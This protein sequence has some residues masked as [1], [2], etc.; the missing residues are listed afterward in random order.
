MAIRKCIQIQVD[1]VGVMRSTRSTVE[2]MDDTTTAEAVTA[3][4][5]I[6][7]PFDEA[8]G[9]ENSIRPIEAECRACAPPPDA[10]AERFTEAWYAR[11][12]LECIRSVRACLA[13]GHPEAGIIAALRLGTYIEQR[14]WWVN[15]GGDVKSGARV[16]RKQRR[17]SRAGVDAR[18]ARTVAE[19]ETLRVTVA[20]YRAKHSYSREH[21]TRALAAHCA[22]A[23]KRK[24]AGVRGRL[25]V[26]K[27]R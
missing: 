25:D 3:V 26:L 6:M 17:A 14:K 5:E 7:A 12:I 11:T 9:F 10:S 23:L 1:P 18:K 8:S 19:D 24:E 16:R 20:A 21:S 2:W 4:D 27:L 15:Q 13:A 22:H